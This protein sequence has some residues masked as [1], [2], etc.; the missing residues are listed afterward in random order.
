MSKETVPEKY[1][2]LWVSREQNANAA[3][4]PGLDTKPIE[5]YEAL[6][7]QGFL[8]EDF[9]PFYS[10]ATFSDVLQTYVQ[11]AG[12]DIIRDDGLVYAK[13]LEDNGVKVKFDAYPGMPNGHFNL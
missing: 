5:G 11:V 4:N 12:L 3:G 6:Y 10:T 2:E 7:G 1:K 9:C 13:V 8:S